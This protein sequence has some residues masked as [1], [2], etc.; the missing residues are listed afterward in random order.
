M[1]DLINAIEQYSVDTENAEK[2]YNLA[3]VYHKM[4]QTASAIS[5]YLRAAERV[6]DDSLAYVCLLKIAD[7]FDRQGNRHFTVRSLYKMAISHAPERP[8]AY[9]LA[10]RFEERNGC[11]MEAYQ[12]AEIALKL[13]LDDKVH[14]R[15]DV[16]YPGKYGLIFEKAVAS[17]W[18]GRS[19]ECRKLLHVL[20]DDYYDEMDET[21]IN[22][23]QNNLSRLGSGPESQAIKT[24]DKS[25]FD[26]LRFKFDGAEYIERNY[27]QVYQDMFVLSMLN[28]K[29]NGKYL[30][31]GSA[32]AYHCNNT[33]LLEKK[34][35]W[36]GI[37][38]EYNP[39]FIPSH[40]NNRSN[41][42]LCQDALTTNYRKLLKEIAGEDKVIDFLQLDCE[43][44]KSTFEI[45]LSMPFEEY[46]FA[47]ITYEHDHYVDMTK[48]YRSRSRNYLKSQ[49]YVLV[50]ND[51]SPDGMSTF[52]DWWVHPD[53]IEPEV[54][55]KMQL[56]DDN[57]K[58]VEHYMLAG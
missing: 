14:Y 9:Y 22:A 15:L 17:W 23:V 31:I 44:S 19:S 53:L 26:K 10:S 48:T 43:P 11:Y 18:I 54:M 33:A 1:N 3:T 21:H 32:D 34:F 55:K 30:E 16:D 25:K 13:K 8:E 39:S 27:S 2:N 4:G 5:Y 40:V 49:G 58:H 35:G 36:T 20:A 52:E 38:I 47:V 37:G 24:Y 6:N 45:L 50:A 42:V 51:I 7:C 29:R 57:I 46:K 28:G 12:Y 41:K 56:V